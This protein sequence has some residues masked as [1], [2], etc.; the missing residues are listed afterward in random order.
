MFKIG[1]LVQLKQQHVVELVGGGYPP[2]PTGPRR[3]VEIT[4]LRNKYR[5]ALIVEGALVVT[6]AFRWSDHFEH[7]GG[8]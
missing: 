4:M 7:I 8:P 5:Q 2:T 6:D 3:V 1:D